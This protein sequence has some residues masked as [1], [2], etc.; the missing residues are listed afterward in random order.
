LSSRKSEALLG[1]G[2]TG[3]VFVTTLL[4]T[5]QARAEPHLRVATGFG[6]VQAGSSGNLHVS[7]PRRDA[8]ADYGLSLTAV[9]PVGQLALGGRGRRWTFAIFAEGAWYRGRSKQDN[10]SNGFGVAFDS[11]VLTWFVGPLFE[12]SLSSAPIRIGWA[13]GWTGALFRLERAKSIQVSINDEKEPQWLNAPAAKFWFGGDF[14]LDLGPH[15]RLGW[16]L[17][18]GVALSDQPSYGALSLAFLLDLTYR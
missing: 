5:A 6:I 15:A 18:L 14:D 13:V 16:R 1:H 7:A 11:S 12:V 2:I 3:A 4:A 9:G 17:P 8:S 10:L